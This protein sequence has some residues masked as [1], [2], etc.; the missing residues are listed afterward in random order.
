MTKPVNRGTSTEKMHSTGD[1]EKVVGETPVNED[2]S[3]LRS[4]GDSRKTILRS[5][6]RVTPDQ[7]R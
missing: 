6:A 7:R 2:E 3:K 5:S 4:T 1:S